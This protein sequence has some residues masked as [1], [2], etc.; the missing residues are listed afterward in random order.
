MKQCRIYQCFLKEEDMEVYVHFFNF[1]NYGDDLFVLMLANRFPNITFHINGV[2]ENLIAFQNQKNIVMHYDTFCLKAVNKIGKKILK[3]DINFIRRARKCEAVIYIG[4][5]LFIQPE[6]RKLESYYLFNK[7]LSIAGKPFI[8]MGANFGPYRDN[9]FLDFFKREFRGYYGIS[10][11]DR[12][13][14]D[15]FSELN[16]VI[17][18]PDILFNIQ[19]LYKDIQSKREDSQKYI[20]FS[21]YGRKE[22][23]DK[24]SYIVNIVRKISQYIDA[25][26]HIKLIS[27]CECQGDLAVCNEVKDR[28]SQKSYVEIINYDGNPET[29]VGCIANA[30]FVIGSRFHAVVTALAYRVPVLPIIYSNKTLN[31]LKDIGYAGKYI[32]INETNK[33][34]FEFTEM[35]RCTDNAVDINQI[36]QES[37]KHFAGFESILVK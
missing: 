25:G 18:A 7:N 24:E 17:Y 34:D 12:A 15:L 11:R 13:S 14:Y 5:S 9:E 27:M 16:N 6:E 29:V 35:S 8:I 20:V 31:M 22:L 23:K 33:L 2:R 1:K 32:D 3:K 19:Q 30:E 10:L 26:Y 28:I 36:S 37:N 21:L 4:G